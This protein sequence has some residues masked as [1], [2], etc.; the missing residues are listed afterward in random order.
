MAILVKR[1]ESPQ[2]L[3]GVRSLRLRVFVEEQG[4][5]REMELDAL[6]ATALH[7]VAVQDG[8]IVGTGRLILDAPAHG[9]IGR[10]AVSLPLRRQGIGTDVLAFLEDCAHSL[11]IQ[12][13]TLHAQSYVKEFYSCRGYQEE[14]E[15]FLEAGIQHIQMSKAL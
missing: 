6:D 1:A 9:V 15:P 14:G 13:I 2:E 4:V 5:P 3:E 10:M 7:A 8:A 11:G 12:R